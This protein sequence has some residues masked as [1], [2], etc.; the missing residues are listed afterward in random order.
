M[1]TC[2]KPAGEGVPPVAVEGLR[3]RRRLRLRRQGPLGLALP[4]LRPPQRR[5][6]E[7]NAGE[8]KRT[9]RQE[10]LPKQQPALQLPNDLASKR[11]CC[12]V[13]KGV[14]LEELNTFVLFDKKFLI[15]D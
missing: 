2:C 14:W 7:R 9:S 10:A 5:H 1:Y 12:S 13:T 8:I 11:P 6:D 15:L 3:H 4:P